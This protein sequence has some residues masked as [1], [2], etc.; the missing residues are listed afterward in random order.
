MI[1]VRLTDLE[2]AIADFVA[3]Q[4]NR[5]GIRAGAAKTKHGFEGS[6][7]DLHKR[8]CR[9][10]MAFAKGMNRYW[11][12]SGCTYHLD[13]DVGSVQIRTTSHVHGCLLVRP[14]EG[15]LDDPWVLVV[16]EGSDYC[17]VGWMWGRDARRDKWLRDPAGRPPAYFVPQEALR[18]V[19]QS[20]GR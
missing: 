7:I 4:R 16:G 6:H 1:W 15:A 10:E 19:T 20:R 18:P 14:G 8:G 3:E 13:D 2:L 11:T 5:D 12:G 17:I 9:G